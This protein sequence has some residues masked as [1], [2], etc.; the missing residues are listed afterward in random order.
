MKVAG[1]TAL[2]TATAAVIGVLL[3]FGV[4]VSEAQGN[5]IVG[6]V[7]AL[8]ALAPLVSGWFTRRQVY[9]PAT[10]AKMLDRARKPRLPS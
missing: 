7:I 1:I 3:A 6:A 4:G 8:A 2:A 10:V 5:A 9:A